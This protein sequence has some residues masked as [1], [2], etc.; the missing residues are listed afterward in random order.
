MYPIPM[1]RVLRQRQ[2]IFSPGA[3]G[4]ESLKGNEVHVTPPTE[5]ETYCLGGLMSN[6]SSLYPCDAAAM[7]EPEKY[8]LDKAEAF[9]RKSVY[10][11]RKPLLPVKKNRGRG[12]LGRNKTKVIYLAVLRQAFESRVGLRTRFGFALRKRADFF[13]SGLLRCG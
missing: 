10:F 12:Y 9:L 7:F 1:R 13:G 11:C 2:R 8:S 6:L 4:A 5:E 3:L